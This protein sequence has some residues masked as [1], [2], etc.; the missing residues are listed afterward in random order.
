[1]TPALALLA[2]LSP[3]APQ[4]PGRALTPGSGQ[5]TAG[6]VRPGRPTA[7]RIVPSGAP[8]PEIRDH[9]PA[10]DAV[11]LPEPA[12]MRATPLGDVLERP[13]GG[14]PFFLGFASGDYRPGPGERV[15]P[16]LYAQALPV[17]PDGPRISRGDPE[18]PDSPASS[19]PL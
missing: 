7:P 12:V 3:L 15:D 18:P 5:P 14:D 19:D 11:P 1:M 6:L 13:A 17:S 4:N 9:V 16:G 2:L 8:A 10:N